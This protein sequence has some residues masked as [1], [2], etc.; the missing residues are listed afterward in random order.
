[1]RLVDLNPAFVAHGGNGVTDLDD[2]PIPFRPGVGLMFDCPCGNPDCP[3]IYVDFQNPIDG[4][5]PAARG[6]PTWQRKGETFETLTLKP[7]IR[8]LSHCRWHGWV[9]DGEVTGD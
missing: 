8:K 6:V 1:M 5:P 2:E 7:S 4:G 9:T 3:S